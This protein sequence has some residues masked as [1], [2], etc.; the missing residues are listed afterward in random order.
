MKNSKN[1]RLL[2]IEPV[3]E[4]ITAAIGVLRLAVF[5]D[6]IDESALR[7]TQRGILALLEQVDPA[8]QDARA[9][10]AEW[11]PASEDIGGGA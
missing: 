2:D 9:Y 11:L 3:A 7:A 10:T 1:P 4:A 8:V 6:D 5:S